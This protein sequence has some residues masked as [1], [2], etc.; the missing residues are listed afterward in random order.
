M[1]RLL[2]QL[3][4]LVLLSFTASTPA[5]AQA[6]SKV[7]SL[8]AILHKYPKEDTIRAKLLIEL[9]NILIKVDIKEGLIC[10]DKALT[11]L[12][13]FP[14]AE[15]K[16][17]AFYT[18]AE[19]LKEL[20]R[21]TEAFELANKALEIY[22]PLHRL[23]KMA[24][25]HLLLSNIYAGRT[26]IENGKKQCER[27]IALAEQIGDMRI[28][29]DALNAI[30]VVYMGSSDYKASVPYHEQA[31][32]LALKYQDK[33]AE[34]ISLGSLGFCH[35]NLGN[36]TKAIDCQQ[37]ALRINENV[38]NDYNLAYNCRNL[39]S[40]YMALREPDK[41]LPYYKKGISLAAK[42]GQ[43]PLEAE[44]YV[45]VGNAYKEM[46]RYEEAIQSIKKGMAI[47]EKKGRN[48]HWGQLGLVYQAMGEYV[49]ANRCFQEAIIESKK[50]NRP[51][52]VAAVLIEIGRIY[53]SAPDSE[54]IKM[55][56]NPTECYSKALAIVNE[57]LETTKQMRTPQ[58]TVKAL[59]VLSIIYEKN[60]DYTNAY[61][62]Y[63]EYITLKDSIRGEEV[64]EQI[65]RKEIQ[66]EFDKK[67][68]ELK[69][70]QQL[71]A[72]ELEQ[73]RLLT[74]QRE[75]DL[76]L[77]RQN[78][79]LKE[80]AL[81]LSNREK[82]LEHLAYLKEQAEK[83]EKAQQLSLSQER[84]K[85][86]ERD[87][88]LKNFELSAQQKQNLY[89][90][91]L[92]VVLFV[93]L[94][95]MFY[96]YNALKKQK[97]IISQQNELNEHTIAIL[98]HDIK[99]PLLGVKLMLKR[100]NKD[101]PFV[102]QASQSLEG[103]INAVNGILTNLLKMKKLALT[104][105]DKNVQ[106]NAN[107]VVKSVL[108]ELN[109]AIQTKGLHIENELTEGVVLPIAPEKLQIIVH[110]LLS[111]AVKYS[112][113]NQKI[114]ISQEG[115]GFCMQDFGIG[116]S[117]EQRSKLMREVTA[118]QRGTSQ[119]RGNGLGLFLVGTMLQGEAIKVIFDSPEIGGTI[120]KVLV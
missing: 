88:N 55:G 27:A 81:A 50:S 14:V 120:A 113:P 9:S 56:V 105:K 49:E 85:G 10:S 117:P 47:N 63:K 4:L 21:R 6:I 65:T 69:Y 54:L 83:Q 102:E 59:E 28:K 82:D 17:D 2:L 98:S 62:T 78:L 75:Q 106:A 7:D 108:Q 5:F 89:L 110:N 16:A 94:G 23:K 115:K 61:N 103:Q 25:V 80:Q 38:G 8:T 96:F 76:L 29:V 64:K 36:Y 43:E 42:V 114:R 40:I 92:A 70:Q 32:D 91:L 73:Q 30:G 104:K 13:K 31:A 67:E 97:N 66:F 71:T 99:E 53:T 111:N 74:A 93:G 118:S 57:A 101:D 46:K 12:E 72:G 100:L 20:S 109:V 51:G 60:K 48:P 79:T 11:I 1:K 18:K 90:G 52:N 33:K 37:K 3:T 34:A 26:D 107:T 58:R 86:K 112:F 44:L 19:H 116:L 95:M 68:T 15:L 45:M 119:E 87:L 41:A 22:E 35:F 77:N 39:G 84:E 24:N